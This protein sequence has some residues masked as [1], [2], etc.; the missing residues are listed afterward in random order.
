MKIKCIV[1]DDEPLSQ[2]ILRKFTGD[3]PALELRAICSNAFEANDVLQ[4]DSVQLVFLDINMPGISGIRFIRTLVDPPLVIFTTAYPEYAVEG[5]EV[6]AVDFL[7]KPFSYERF[8]KA[9][10][11]ASEKLNLKMHKNPANI[12]YLLLKSDKKIYKVNYRDIIYIESYGDYL[13][14][15]TPE[16]CLVVHEKFKNME[17]R[18]PD[19]KFIRVHKSFIIAIDKIKFIEGNQINLTNAVIPVGL[20]FRDN[21]QRMIK[22]DENKRQV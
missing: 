12:D 18:L 14:V 21:L 5:F 16:K 8:L 6:D 19:D 22:N 1:V 11:K 4:T 2:D 17:E 3:T 9:V 10:N 20:G 15:I 7:L 13:K